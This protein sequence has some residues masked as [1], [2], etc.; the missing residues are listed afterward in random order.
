MRRRQLIIFAKAPVLGRVKSRLARGIGP[1][2]ALAFYRRT[3][4]VLIRRVAR[5]RRWQ[6]VLAVA[7]DAAARRGRLWPGR[8]ARR[9]Q[10]SGDLGA[11]MA[12]MFRTSARGPVAIVGADIPDLGARHVARAFRALGSADAVLG[13]AGDG[14]YWLIGLRRGPVPRNLFDPVRWSSEHALADTLANLRGRQVRLLERLDDVDDANDWRR[15]K[16]CASARGRQPG[17]FRARTPMLDELGE[18]RVD[19]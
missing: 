10:G 6:T 1:S 12:R 13:P 2:A 14:G 15:W 19:R 4:T 9:A 11:R 3:L 5:D 18:L 16:A 7:P 8:C 17:Q